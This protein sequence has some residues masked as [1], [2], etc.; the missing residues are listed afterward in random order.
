MVPDID[1]SMLERGAHLFTYGHENSSRLGCCLNNKKPHPPI[2]TLHNRNYAV[3]MG[4]NGEIAHKHGIDNS[5]RLGRCLKREN[6]L[7]ISP[8][9]TNNFTSTLPNPSISNPTTGN[10]P[11]LTTTITP[12]CSLW[13]PC[14]DSFQEVC[15]WKLEFSV[16]IYLTAISN[17]DLVETVYT[18]DLRKKTYHY[19]MSTPTAAPNIALAVGL[20]LFSSPLLS[21]T[22]TNVATTMALT[23]T[24]LKRSLP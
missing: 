11:N 17:G 9:F 13:F 18:P 23:S 20:D 5:S 21:I 19:Y 2:Y 14:I 10:F 1:G 15:T 3:V 16:D 4:A 7:F 24:T 22:S 8:N 12:G 6:Y